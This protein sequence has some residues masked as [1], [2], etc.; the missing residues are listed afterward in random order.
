MVVS[1][2][3][4]IPQVS[5][6]QETVTGRVKS[7]PHIPTASNASRDIDRSNVLREKVAG[8]R[9]TPSPSTARSPRNA[10]DLTSFPANL[11]ATESIIVG[12]PADPLRIRRQWRCD[13]WCRARPEPCSLIRPEAPHSSGRTV[14][15]TPPASPDRFPRPYPRPRGP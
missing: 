10:I 2:M 15:S 7:G 6:Q 4:E 5:F 1:G 8:S 12:V 3:E 11:A 14:S 13:R 9:R